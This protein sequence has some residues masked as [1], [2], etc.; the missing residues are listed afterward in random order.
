MFLTL[1]IHYCWPSIFYKNSFADTLGPLGFDIYHALMVDFDKRGTRHRKLDRTN[2]L[3]FM[4]DEDYVA[5]LDR[6]N[7]LNES[8]LWL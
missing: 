1:D 3:S 7:N 4:L 6:T 8:V 2:N 5:N